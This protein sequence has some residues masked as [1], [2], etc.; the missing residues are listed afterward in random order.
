[1]SRASVKQ[2][3]LAT[4]FRKAFAIGSIGVATALAA[5]CGSDNP[6]ADVNHPC[7]LNSECSGGLVCSFGLCHAECAQVRDC[8]AN[9]RCVSINPEDGGGKPIRLCQEEKKCSYNSDC[10]D[11]LVCA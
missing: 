1:M 6:P 5:A 8:P 11:P 4:W 9:Q 2:S 7:K 3:P 10:F